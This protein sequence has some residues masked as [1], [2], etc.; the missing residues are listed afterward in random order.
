MYGLGLTTEED[1]YAYLIANDYTDG[2]ASNLAE[3]YVRSKLPQFQG[4]EADRTKKPNALKSGQG[5]LDSLQ[6]NIV[7]STISKYLR[8]DMPERALEYFERYAGHM[9]EEQAQ[10]LRNLIGGGE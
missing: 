10:K 3:Y 6:Y 4:D 2:E 9:T 7:Y 8:N 5:V 1:A